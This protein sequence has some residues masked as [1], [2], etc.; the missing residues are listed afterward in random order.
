MRSPVRLAAGLLVLGLLATGCVDPRPEEAT[1]VEAPRSVLDEIEAR[2]SVDGQL[3][4]GSLRIADGFTFV[5]AELARDGDPERLRGDLLTWATG[6]LD[7]GEYFAV[8]VYARESSS[9]PPAPFDVRQS[10]VVDSRA[11]T[12]FDAGEP[13]PS[14][15]VVDPPDGEG[16]T[17]DE[18]DAPSTSIGF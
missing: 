16:D 18:P 2:L 13:D 11:C 17:T 4:H 5:S 1:C 14:T 6:S 9:W 12:A 8:D 7:V 3:R 10:G 15:G